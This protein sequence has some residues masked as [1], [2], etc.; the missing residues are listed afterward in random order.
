MFNDRSKTSHAAQR[1]ICNWFYVYVNTYVYV[2]CGGVS[3]HWLSLTAITCD[4]GFVFM[5]GNVNKLE[6]ISGEKNI[7]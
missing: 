1:F 4:V 7:I 5:L 6:I 3:V 2:T